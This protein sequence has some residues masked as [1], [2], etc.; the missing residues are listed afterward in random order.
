M[1]RSSDVLN[2][3]GA[4]LVVS[5]LMSVVSPDVLVLHTGPPIAAEHADRHPAPENLESV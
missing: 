3:R 2:E 5:D 1:N 4:T